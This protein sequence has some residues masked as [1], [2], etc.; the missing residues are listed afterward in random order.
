MR[1]FQFRLVMGVIRTQPFFSRSEGFPIPKIP[2]SGRFLAPLVKP[3]G[4]GMTRGRATQ[5]SAG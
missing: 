5:N 3:R 2:F 1:R 4:F